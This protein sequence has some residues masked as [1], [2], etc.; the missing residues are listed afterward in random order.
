MKKP[1]IVIIAGGKNSR[2]APLNTKTHKGFLP[3]VGKPIIQRGFED[4]VAHGFKD[5]VLVLSPKDYDGNGFSGFLDKLDLDLNIT[6]I[7]QE[8]AKGQG[9]ALLSA[10]K[11]LGDYF[12]LAS[13]YYSNIG[14][15]AEKL[16]QKQQ[17]TG[18]NCVYSGTKTTTPELYGILKFDESDTTKVIGIVEKPKT[19]TQPSDIKI[20][21]VYLF[22]TPFIQELANKNQSEYSLED[23]IDSYAKKNHTTWIRN[24]QKIQSLKYPWHLFNLFQQQMEQEKTHISAQAKISDT[25][26]FDETHGP[27]IIDDNA[28]I[29]DFVK[30]VGPCY[31][32]KNTLVGDYSFVRGSSLEENAV[33]G[34]N[35]EVVRCILFENSSIHFGYL[36]DSILGHGTKIGAGLITANKRLDRK[37]IRVMV[38]KSLVDTGT[39]TLGIITGEKAI[40]GI[41]VNTM[42]GIT[43]GANAQVHPGTT[44]T[45]NVTRVENTEKAKK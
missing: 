35:T 13:P 16:W 25:A 45:R 44:V 15:I 31:I 41:R 1:T 10:Q 42:P 40:L 43:V 14:S 6:T 2:F 28:R 7:L 33:V 8:D 27:V 37:N 34:A 38:K 36:A 18:A 23:A 12:V 5:V 22:D 9:D 29:G 39:N 21:S 26:I 24:T 3:L 32:G 19:G 17:E 4:L 30:L 11:H 20:D